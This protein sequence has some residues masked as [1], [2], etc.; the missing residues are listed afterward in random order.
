MYKYKKGDIDRLVAGRFPTLMEDVRKVIERSELE[1]TGREGDESFLWEHTRFVSSMA[2]HISRGE[3]LDPLLPVVTSLFHD[4]G[5]FENGIYHEGDTPEEETAAKIAQ[6]LLGNA[7]MDSLSIKLVIEALLALYNDNLEKNMVSKIVHDADFLTKFGY[8]GF[9]GFFEKSA[10]RGMAMGS[11]ILKRVSK[12]LTYAASLVQNMHTASGRKMALSR[13]ENTKMLFRN[14]LGEMAQAGIAEYEIREMEI[15]CCKGPE[16]IIPLA[17][18]L[19]VRC[20][21]CGSSVKTEF[22]VE[23]GVKCEK[24]T[25]NIGCFRCSESSEYDLSFC[26]P[27]LMGKTPGRHE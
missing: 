1:Y 15:N 26:L 16:D 8:M 5:K 12:E 3:S 14:Y 27:E 19:P 23:R 7:G 11:S 2:M 21:G 6:R 20:P 9:A 25:V 13:S 24:L 4:C 18:V 10:L 17:L 22:E